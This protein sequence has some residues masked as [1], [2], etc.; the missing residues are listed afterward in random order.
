MK[1]K[2]KLIIIIGLTGLISFLGLS[3]WVVVS[4]FS[5]GSERMQSL[6]LNMN[7]SSLEQKV[8]YFSGINTRE[9]LNH[10]QTLS[11]P[12]LWLE[13]TLEANLTSLKSACLNTAEKECIDQNCESHMK[14]IKP[15]SKGE[16]I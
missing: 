14:D 6:N 7:L 9:C 8:N 5:F 12:N 11:Q 10:F 3:I 15:K 2:L 13:K 4:L 1:K 16:F